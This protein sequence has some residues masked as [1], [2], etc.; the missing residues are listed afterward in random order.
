MA[1]RRRLR[2]SFSGG[3]GHHGGDLRRDGEGQGVETPQASQV[4]EGKH[5]Q[6]E[7]LCFSCDICHTSFMTDTHTTGQHST[8]LSLSSPPSDE[9]ALICFS[10]LLSPLMS[11]L[12]HF[13]YYFQPLQF[14]SAV[15]LLC[16]CKLFTYSIIIGSSFKASVLYWME[17]VKKGLRTG[18]E[19]KMTLSFLFSPNQIYGPHV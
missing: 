16:P 17:E 2:R 4:R 11:L 12:T 18:K 1:A 3:L 6:E 10:L 15:P 19:M 9:R 8:S 7:N 14:H 5:K 13:Y